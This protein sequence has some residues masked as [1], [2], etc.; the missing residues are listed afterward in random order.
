MLTGVS[1]EKV[2]APVMT[3]TS[4]NSEEPCSLMSVTTET[5]H[6]TLFCCRLVFLTRLN[7]RW[8]NGKSAIFSEGSQNQITA[9]GLAVGFECVPMSQMPNVN[10]EWTI[11]TRTTN[12]VLE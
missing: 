8:L 2:L 4:S 1:G 7:S 3:D 6:Q 9:L 11:V 10:A 5:F 12:P